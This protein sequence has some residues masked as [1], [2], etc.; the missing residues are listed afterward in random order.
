M[1]LLQL[2][3][4]TKNLNILYVEDSLTAR[5]VGL[6]MLHNF[7]ENI[8]IAKNGK[9]AFDLYKEYYQRNEKFYDIVFSDLEMPIMDGE[10]LSYLI[11]DFN[12]EQSIVIISGV[13]DF[14]TVV[15][16]INL[17]LK[18]FISKPMQEDILTEILVDIAKRIR[19]KKLLDLDKEE[20]EEY[21]KILKDREE[22]SQKILAIKIKELE[23]FHDALELS[24]I[25]AK[26]DQQG[27]II[28][29]N[30]KF[31]DISGYTQ[32]ELIGS[33]MSIIKSGKRSKAF[34]KKIWNKIS[35]NEIYSGFFENKNKKGLMYY[36]ESTISPI[37]NQNNEILEYISV[38]HDMT[39]LMKS[40]EAQ[41]EAEKAKQDFFVN[42][43]HEMR[44]PLNSILSFS[45]LLPKHIK[46][47]EKALQMLEVITQTGNDLKN[48][49]ESV[50]DIGKLNSDNIILQ[51]N[52]FDTNIELMKCFDLYKNKADEK[53]IE[54]KIKIDTYLPVS[55]IGD[56]DRIKQVLGILID[57]ALKFISSSEPKV[58]LSVLYDK[59]TQKLICEV[60]D[61]GI[62]ISKDEQEKIFEIKQLDS[63][64]TRSYE[65]AGLGLHVASK[66]LKLMNGN[67]SLK[68]IPN[69]GSL[70]CVEFPLEQN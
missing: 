68:S 21:N 66:L 32:N 31:C 25:V 65:G 11:L 37:V 9:E 15:K 29:V 39:Q 44:T 6:N 41:K 18:K 55:L 33:P 54:Y 43:S 64:L 61:N 22:E 20:L 48:L 52:I 34:Y 56:I 70:F 51:N 5:N 16:L 24:A 40:L 14:N 2:K 13:Q 58:L 8:D 19:K 30:Q 10:E 17:G 23:E 47:N 36:I 46:D 7:F 67:I 60:K 27:V 42:I 35:N 57:N 28:Y 53:G 45:A 12:I 4:F 59:T 63:S 62:G 26:T 38:S 49:V 1:D 3:E 69:K 50:I